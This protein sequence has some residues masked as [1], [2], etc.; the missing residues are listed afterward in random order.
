MAKNKLFFKTVI[1]EYVLLL[2]KTEITIES[3][4]G[5]ITQ[6]VRLFGYLVDLDDEY[7]YTGATPENI[8]KI[9]PI[10][11][12]AHIEI[13]EPLEADDE[14]MAILKNTTNEGIPN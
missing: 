3:E 11:N 7:L 1:G 4:S 2:L 10:D 9:T 12:I 14:L 6:P 13:A 5:L 8:S